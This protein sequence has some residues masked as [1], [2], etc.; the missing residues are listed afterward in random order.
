MQ[1]T[2]ASAALVGAAVTGTI[3]FTTGFVTQWL[4]RSRDR[5]Q[6]IWEK[7]ASVYEDVLVMVRRMADDRKELI[8]SG[9]AGPWDSDLVPESLSRVYAK[10]EIYGTDLLIAAHEELGA[11]MKEWLLA[12]LAWKG[13]VG[14]NPV[15]PKP[16][17]DVLWDVFLKK[18]EAAEKIDTAFVAKI[19]ADT[20]AIR[21]KRRW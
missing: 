5:E 7:R 16:G 4:T 21:P 13:S 8:R 15:V 3:T 14:E 10:L 9:A 6:R 17:E 11:A 18:A 19:R 12:F 20:L 2:P 1:L